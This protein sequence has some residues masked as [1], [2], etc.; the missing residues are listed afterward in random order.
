VHQVK[1]MNTVIFVARWT[2]QMCQFRVSVHFVFDSFAAY[3]AALTPPSDDERR[4][5][6]TSVAS[7]GQE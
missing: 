4:R 3:P 6:T 2:S 1:A 7:K 5:A